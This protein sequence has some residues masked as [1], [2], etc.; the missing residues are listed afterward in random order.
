MKNALA[1][2]SLILSFTVNAYS[3]PI[4]A[5]TFETNITFNNFSIT[6]KDKVYKATDLIKEVI[7][8]DEFRNAVLNH[9][10]NGKKQFNDNNGLTNS[11][12]YTKILQGAEKLTPS[13]NNAMDVT[14]E[15]YTGNNL[16]V[17]YTNPGT[18]VIYMNTKF[19]NT[20]TPPSVSANLIHEWLHKL[21]FDHAVQYSPSRDYS[22]P[23]AI[24]SIMRRIAS[25]YN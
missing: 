7:A 9:E 4:E 14:L 1:V 3:V 16:T 23:Y 13:K 21:G 15:L 8:S 19:F 20:Y 24:G 10:Y 18:R 5:T 2:L 12:I 22:V 25:K 6:Q 11:Q 17:G